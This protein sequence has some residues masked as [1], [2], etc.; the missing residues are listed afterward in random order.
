MLRDGSVHISEWS[1][2]AHDIGHID[3]PVCAAR[4]H[5]EPVP[6]GVPHA[7]GQKPSSIWTR[8]IAGVQQRGLFICLG[9]EVFS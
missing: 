3:N 6:G 8:Q 7:S 1:S 9:V 4:A 5:D 2:E